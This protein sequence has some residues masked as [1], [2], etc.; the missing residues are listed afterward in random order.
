MVP[1]FEIDHLKY[2]KMKSYY[3]TLLLT[4]HCKFYDDAITSS[5]LMNLSEVKGARNNNSNTRLNTQFPYNSY[6][7]T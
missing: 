4:M 1:N 2:S 3:W 5:Y 7:I 6:L